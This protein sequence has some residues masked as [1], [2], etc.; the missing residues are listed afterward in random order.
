MRYILV[1]CTLMPS[2]CWAT[3]STPITAPATITAVT[4]FRSNAKITNTASASVP[5]GNSEIV[6]T[7]ISQYANGESLQI[8]IEGGA[9]LLSATFRHDYAKEQPAPEAARLIAD[10]IKQ[11]RYQLDKLSNIFNILS[12]ENTLLLQN[13]NKLGTQPANSISPVVS[14]AEISTAIEYYRK[15]ATDIAQSMLD[16][17]I[18]RS[19]LTDKI[20]A[21]TQRQ[22]RLQQPQS[23]KVKGEV[24]LNIATNSSS[25]IRITCSYIVGNVSWSPTYDL[26][27][28]APN[29]PLQLTYKAQIYQ[30]TDLDWKNI[31]LSVATGNPLQNN[32]RP[33]LTPQYLDITKRIVYADAN[34]NSS[35][36]INFKREIGSDIANQPLADEYEKPQYLSAPPPS[37]V[38]DVTITDNQLNAVF[39]IALSQTIQSNNKP[40]TV[41]LTDYQIDADFQYHAVPKK[42]RAAFLLANISDW[43]QYHLLAGNANLFMENTY[44][45]KSPITPDT[46]YDTLFLSLGRDE[47]INIE[48]IP[49]N[50]YTK[51]KFIGTNKS[52]TFAYDIVVRNNKNVAIDLEIIDQVPISQNSEIKIEL[53]ES[54]K[55]EYFAEIGKLLWRLNLKPNE[56]KK[57]RLQYTVKSP[58]EMAVSGL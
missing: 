29:K 22:Q 57:L 33:I 58:K 50:E 27:Y 31:K 2:L 48:R 1:A 26:K 6:L 16:I 4:V 5:A 47:R 49:L 35:N 43:G 54:S 3:N 56:T 32:S 17:N 34:K 15:R 41:L 53:D 52:Q 14:A 13:N 28:I 46:A 38:Y 44:I 55:A 21:M 30:N 18:Q 20:N 51:T 40:H 19:E 10:S 9:T 11:V 7:G 39:D 45:G 25:L 24:V 23:D 42:D 37:P 8:E 36:M 12:Q